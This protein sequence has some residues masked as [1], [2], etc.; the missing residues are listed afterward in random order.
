MENRAYAILTG[1]FTLVF[2]TAIVVA[3]IWF[4]GDARGYNEYLLETRYSVNGLYR[5]ADVRYRGISVGKV[6][7]LSVDP[8]DIRIILI[9]VTIEKNIPVT[10]GTFGQLGY[11]GVTGLAYVTIDD[12]GSN[13]QMLSQQGAKLPRI[14]VKA[15]VLD[16]LTSAGQ[17]LLN[18]A[19]EVM[20]RLN[21]LVN[22]ENQVRLSQTLA[23]FE[24]A[25]AQL[26]PAL[27]AIPRV[28][29][30]AERFFSEENAQRLDSSLI[31]LEHTGK[32]IAPLAEDS[33]KVLAD[34][35]LLSQNLNRVT[36]EI[37]SE[38]TD[39]T[40]PR[41]NT[42][43]DQ[44]SKDSRDLRRVLLQFEREPRTL[45]FGRPPAMPGPGEP[46]FTSGRK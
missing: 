29:A 31:S 40:L 37:S 14:P 2:G 8:N 12:D 34:I 6:T 36:E 32:A 20:Q 30:R 5:Q 44:L 41:V 26:E 13:P 7:N 24:A 16:D 4:R 38:I 27:R 33:R 9:G 1:L 18:Q 15:N 11:Q 22:E 21:R 28:A 17:A 39:S 25:S 45:L 43:I 19:N 46:G 35:G 23:N 10:K 3:F 42:L